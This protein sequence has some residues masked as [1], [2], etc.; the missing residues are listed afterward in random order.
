MVRAAVR[1][2]C[3]EEGGE[4]KGD[5]REGGQIGGAVTAVQA[6]G[7]DRCLEGREG[8]EWQPA[9]ILQRMPDKTYE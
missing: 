5:Y 1:W 4:E 9:E 3:V 2:A 7:A 8:E 6:R